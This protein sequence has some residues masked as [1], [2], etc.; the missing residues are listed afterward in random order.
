MPSPLLGTALVTQLL[1][2]YKLLQSNCKASPF[3]S[4]S[5]SQN[6]RVERE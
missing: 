1:K 5:N 4:W 2:H 3:P 6:T